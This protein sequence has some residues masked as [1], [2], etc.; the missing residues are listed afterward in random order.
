MR[1]V[2]TVQES[3]NPDGRVLQLL[4]QFR[5]MLNHCIRV[6]VEENLSSLK[7]LSL[8]CYAQ[9]S[10]Y[11]VMSYYKL[12]AIS[13]ATG[14]LRNYRKAKRKN[15][16]IKE[17]YARILRL[18]TCYGF[19]IQDGKLLLPL[20]AR[21]HLPIPLTRHVQETIMG[22]EVR[23][24]T[25]TRDRISLAIA[26]EA[27]DVRVRGWVGLDRNLNNVTVAASDAATTTHDLTEAGRVKATYRR[28]RSRFRRNDHRIRKSIAEK[29]GVKEREKVKQ[30]LHHA[31][32][33]IVEQAKQSQYGIVME[34]LTG[35]RRLY[36]KGNGQGRGYRAR[37]NSWSYGELQR[38]I[39]YKARWEG[40]PVIYVNPA[41]TS[42][43]CSMCGSRMARIPE[44]KRLLTCRSCGFTVDRDVNAARNILARGLRFS[45]VAHSVEA[46][47]AE[48]GRR[49]VIRK[50]DGWEL[51]TTTHT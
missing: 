25:I 22:C 17:P 8:K 29:Y 43:K 38:Q 35:M 27:A 37:M 16:H 51:T 11:D 12:C 5:L 50:V 28:V 21:E 31:S 36:R 6:G 20:H 41:G 49:T 47:V 46:M 9:L 44:E 33:A 32:K 34:T 14:I 19:K 15:P 3:Y 23:S 48:P 13:S 2:K 40:L 45:P 18:T 24:V 7:A 26:R 4:D 1:A 39:E 42:R 10:E 30:I